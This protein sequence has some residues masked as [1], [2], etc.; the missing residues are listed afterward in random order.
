MGASQAAAERQHGGG[1][2]SVHIA[3][4]CTGW[5]EWSW[6]LPPLPHVM[7]AAAFDLKHNLLFLLDQKSCEA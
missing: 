4:P 2:S 5:K 1:G 3:T 7:V 6:A